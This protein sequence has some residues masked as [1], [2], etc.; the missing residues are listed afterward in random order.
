MT[1]EG[2]E[3]D[4]IRARGERRARRGSEHQRGE[5]RRR[6]KE[7][8]VEEGTVVLRAKFVV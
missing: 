7:G 1:G 8:S 4:G 6:G 3:K 5:V 2:R